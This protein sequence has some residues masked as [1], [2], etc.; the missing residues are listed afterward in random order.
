MF[1]SKKTKKPG[2][3]FKPTQN[4]LKISEI[5]DDLLIMQD[6]TLRSFLE[7]SSTNFE[8]K[9]Q[10]EQDALIFNYQRFLNSLEFPIQILMQSRKMDVSKYIDKL[11][12]IAA[13]QTNE[14]LRIQTT[15]YAEFIDRLVESANVMNK[16]FY[17]IIPYDYSISPITP[18][19]FS[20]LFKNKEQAQ[21]SERAGNFEKFKTLLDER[22][23][24]VAN[25][26]ASVGMRVARMN[27]DRIIELLYNSYNF[28]SGPL[29][30]ADTLGD[31]A[32]EK[33]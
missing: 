25:G 5:R 3:A 17:V 8:L 26:L 29:I 22:T 31:V 13:T 11:K 28:E 7:V 30:K 9:N 2:P 24:G 14:L 18:S 27:T 15:E 10:E 4:F 12:G 16:N 1:G 32:L 20:R 6:G 21:I 33:S 23:G 19:F